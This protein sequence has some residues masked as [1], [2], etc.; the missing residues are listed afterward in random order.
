MLLN[1]ETLFLMHNKSTIS[2]LAF[3]NR[4]VLYF[5]MLPAPCAQLKIW[6]LKVTAICICDKDNILNGSLIKNKN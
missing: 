4:I 1:H 2:I 5:I 3:E 6:K